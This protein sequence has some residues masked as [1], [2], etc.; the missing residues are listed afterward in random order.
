[1][2]IGDDFGITLG[3][4]WYN[5]ERAL[6]PDGPDGPCETVTTMWLLA[7]RTSALCAVYGHFITLT[8]PQPT[9]QVMDFLGKFVS[10]ELGKSCSN[11]NILWIHYDINWLRPGQKMIV[12]IRQ[13]QSRRKVDSMR[14]VQ[15]ISFSI[16]FH[17]PWRIKSNVSLSCAIAPR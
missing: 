1:M 8:G 7:E 3:Q 5:L 4:L 16:Y 6:G 15:M 12:I 14:P 11:L 10:L 9:Q 13:A 17:L 2:Q